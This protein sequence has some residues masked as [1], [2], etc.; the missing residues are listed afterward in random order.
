[1]V[2]R[3]P[4]SQPKKSMKLLTTHGSQATG[5]RRSSEID[6]FL[7]QQS[8]LLVDRLGHHAP[9]LGELA[10]GLA[11]AAHGALSPSWAPSAPANRLPTL[12]QRH[13]PRQTDV[14]AAFRSGVERFPEVA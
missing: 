13:A 4:G 14:Q 10:V 8:V 7:D 3:C 5:S 2:E 1:M 12:S 11:G 6:R 9:G